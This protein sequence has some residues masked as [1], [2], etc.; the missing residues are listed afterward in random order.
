MGKWVGLR[1]GVSGGTNGEA[2]VC[3]FWYSLKKR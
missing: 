1:G 3:K 2:S